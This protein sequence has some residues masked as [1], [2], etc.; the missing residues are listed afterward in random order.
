MSRGKM[1]RAKALVIVTDVAAARKRWG[2]H[3][4]FGEYPEAEVLDALLFIAEEGLLDFTTSAAELKIALTASNRA[5]GAAESRA[6][7]Y[8]SLLDVANKNLKATVLALEDAE[9]KTISESDPM[10]GA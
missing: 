8:K 5:K 3:S 6:I 2:R 1:D 4:G 10:Y 9:K 7:K